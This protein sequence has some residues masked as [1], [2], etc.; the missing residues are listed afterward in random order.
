VPRSFTRVLSNVSFILSA[1]AE[2]VRISSPIA[3][4]ICGMLVGGGVGYG[5]YGW[6]E[7]RDKGSG[8]CGGDVVGGVGGRKRCRRGE[9]VIVQ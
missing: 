8:E 7:L 5:G 4:V 9:T 2:E 3:I 1:R 6:G